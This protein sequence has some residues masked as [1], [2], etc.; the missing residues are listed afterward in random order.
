MSWTATIVRIAFILVSLTPR[1]SAQP[2]PSYT[3]GLCM[4]DVFKI[5]KPQGGILSCTAK[6]VY[7][8]NATVIDGPDECIRGQNITV[9]LTA[10]IH[11]NT[12]RRD[13][14]IYIS[15]S[16]VC[17]ETANGKCASS[18]ERCAVDVLG[19]AIQAK[20]PDWIGV[21]DNHKD[22]TANDTCLDVLP[23]GGGRD[24]DF[25]FQ[26]DL[27]IP[28]VGENDTDKTVSLA[29]CFSWNQDNN[30]WNCDTFGAYPG[31]TSKW[32]PSETPSRQPS[33]N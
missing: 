18:G 2:F 8:N 15:Q 4:N 29:T 10:S 28:C 16:N 32:H 3:L 24:Y 33:L 1:A 6:E 5:Y 26:Q 20:Y 25:T 17:N 13:P 12:D 9:N 30:D 14:A 22:G 11:F 7:A 31:T 23:A 27:L 21:D 19:P